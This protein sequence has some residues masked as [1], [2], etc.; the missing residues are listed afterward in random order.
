MFLL[1]EEGNKV[2]GGIGGGSSD[3]RPR[4]S[5]IFP[6]IFRDAGKYNIFLG[7]VAQSPS[8][9]DP[10]IMSSCNNLMFGQLKNGRDR[11]LVIAATGRSEKGFWSRDHVEFVGRLPQAMM[12]CKLGLSTK[13]REMTPMVMRPAMVACPEPSDAEIQQRFGNGHTGAS[14]G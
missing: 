11:D 9:L 14:R 2:L 1:F 3:E 8:E 7:V 4:H 12:V 13:M 10:G 6:G 5:E